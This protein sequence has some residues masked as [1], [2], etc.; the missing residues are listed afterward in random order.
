MEH[1]PNPRQG[2]EIDWAISLPDNIEHSQSERPY[3]TESL[4]ELYKDKR[5]MFKYDAYIMVIGVCF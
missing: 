2:N 1:L 4:D 5:Q 3:M